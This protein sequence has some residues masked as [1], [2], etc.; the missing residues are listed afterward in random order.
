[1]LEISFTLKV[2]LLFQFFLQPTPCE[3][4]Q[5]SATCKEYVLEQRTTLKEVVRVCEVVY[6]GVTYE[7]LFRQ[8]VRDEWSLRE[9]NED[10]RP[11]FDKPRGLWRNINSESI[12]GISE[13]WW[14]EYEVLDNNR[15]S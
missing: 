9:L 7:S 1:M 6:K 3:I 13:E 8:D 4:S 5:I 10:G 2:V 14:C 11:S 15:H 12:T